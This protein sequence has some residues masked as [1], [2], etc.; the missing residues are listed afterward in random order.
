MTDKKATPAD[1]AGVS[2]KELADQAIADVWGDGSTEKTPAPDKEPAQKEPAPAEAREPEDTPAA[3]EPPVDKPEDIWATAP[4]ALRTAYETQKAEHERLKATWE[5]Q[6]NQTAGLSRKIEELQRAQRKATTARDE[7]SQ[8]DFDE[9][10]KK[11]KALGDEYPDIADPI[12]SLASALKSATAQIS[13]AT[14]A[15]RAA[16]QRSALSEQQKVDK[17]HPDW[18]KLITEDH[19]DEYAAFV[20]DDNEPA[21][22]R[23]AVENNLESVTDADAAIR[24]IAR[25]KERMGL[26][27][28]K[29][30]PDPGQDTETKREEARRKRQLDGAT[31]VPPRGTQ[32]GSVDPVNGDR[33]TNVAWA[34]QKVWGK[35][36]GF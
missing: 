21:W 7:P 23:K 16:E 33:K 14:A 1:T 31:S 13:G 12:N 5:R 36:P 10:D 32:M 27:P 29:D 19:A 3:E 8:I 6:R 34:T 18:L 28:P 26:N 11:L 9:I 30:E 4:E 35:N 22:V 17:A 20:E 2:R 25:F 24:L 15:A